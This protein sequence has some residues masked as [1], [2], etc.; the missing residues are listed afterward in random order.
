MGGREIFENLQGV[1]R[2]KKGNAGHCFRERQLNTVDTLFHAFIVWKLPLND[3]KRKF[4]PLLPHEISFAR[5]LL[6]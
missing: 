4:P 5:S 1:S 3:W 6:V 2:I